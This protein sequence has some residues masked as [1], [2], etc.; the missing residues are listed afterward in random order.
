MEETHMKIEILSQDKI[1]KLDNKV[2][3]DEICKL[4]N[5]N[6]TNEWLQDQFREENPFSA[7]KIHME[8]FEMDTTEEDPTQ[9]DFV[10]AKRLYEALKHI[11]ESIACDPRLWM[12]LTFGKFYPYMKY[13]YNLMSKP[14]NYQ[15]KWVFQKGSKKSALFR[16]GISMLWWYAHITYD[17]TRENPYELTEFCFNHKDF[18][19]SIYSRTYSGSKNV[20]LALIEALKDYGEA[21][22]KIEKKEIY[23]G[24]VKYVSFL[25]GAYLIDLYSR[26]EMY[27]KIYG[28]LERLGDQ[29]EESTKK[30][31]L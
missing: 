12:G 31:T 9:T 22:G 25:G 15:N 10:N 20:R 7:S 24:I 1:D 26:E 29:L 11:P 28:E 4:I 3:H 27:D 16:Q 6:E 21:G 14:K 18:L 19:I 17:E 2:N 30:F 5:A 8:D 13:R 23:N